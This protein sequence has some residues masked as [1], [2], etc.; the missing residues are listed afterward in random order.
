MKYLL[1]AETRSRA[2]QN[3]I[4]CSSRIIVGL[5]A[6]RFWTDVPRPKVKTKRGT[7]TQKGW[8]LLHIGRM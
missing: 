8:I 5:V 1:E 4:L 7:D 2:R 6:A 3:E